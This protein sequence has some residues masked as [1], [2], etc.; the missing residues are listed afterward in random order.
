MFDKPEV[1]I[2][3][4]REAPGDRP[5]PIA[6]PDASAVWRERTIAAALLVALEDELPNRGV[7]VWRDERAMQPGDALG[8]EID[9]ALLSCAGAVIL[10]DNAALE[11]SSWV[12]WESSIL[13]W[14]QRIGMSVRVVPVLIGVAI[15]DLEPAGYGPARVDDLLAL[16]VPAE[17]LDPDA[18]DFGVQV[19]A[20]ATKVADGLGQ[21][22]ASSSGPL[23]IWIDGI[24][25]CLPRDSRWVPHAE[26]EMGEAGRR[27]TLSA[28]PQVVMARELVGSRFERLERLLTVLANFSFADAPKLRQHLEPVWVPSD[29]LTMLPAIT[30]APPGHRRIALNARE[31]G[32]G[33]DVVRRAHPGMAIRP[34][35][36]WTITAATPSA[37]VD[38]CVEAIRTNWG[39]KTPDDIINAHGA[40]FVILSP[41]AIGAADLTTILDGLALA[42]PTV[43]YVVMVAAETIMTLDRLD[44]DLEPGADD[45]AHSLEIM[46][47]D[48]IL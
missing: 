25:D 9:A 36:E 29:I 39:S 5:D 37:A 3:Y 8:H 45:V 19:A 2:S 46:L 41:G 13:T 11:R 23:A 42:Y 47:H 31:A 48:L 26:K 35:M 1:F 6:D 21:L 20:V 44:P 33:T 40:C 12:R 16:L 22:E 32:T 10:I 14:R 24:A 15:A 43:T 34:I 38:D 7:Y 28:S 17:H 30:R 27:L 4:S 18:A